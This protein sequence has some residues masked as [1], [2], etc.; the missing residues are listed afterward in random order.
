M[1]PYIWWVAIG[2][3]LVGI[4]LVTG[5]LYLLFLG[6]AAFAAAI[7]AF[8]GGVLALQ[9]SVAVIV[10]IAAS[11]W[12]QQ[13]RK[14]RVRPVMPALD[15]GQPV[16]FESWL[17]EGHVEAGGA[18]R[19]RVRYRGTI[20]EARIVGGWAATTTTAPG[21]VLYIEAID[22]NTLTVSKSARR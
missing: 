1:E 17:D 13:H 11:I 7:A 3:A 21:E 12:V 19:A 18:R 10:A 2:A 4:E 8:L 20:W 16:N 22:G 6:I 15:I 14:T 5:T 9:V